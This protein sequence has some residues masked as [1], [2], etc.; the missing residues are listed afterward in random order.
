MKGKKFDATPQDLQGGAGWVPTSQRKRSQNVVSSLKD[1]LRNWFKGLIY[2]FLV[3]VLAKVIQSVVILLMIKSVF[4]LMGSSKKSILFSQSV[5]DF[6]FLHGVVMWCEAL[7]KSTVATRLQNIL[8]SLNPNHSTSNGFINSNSSDLQIYVFCYVIIANFSPFAK[9]RWY[10]SAFEGSMGWVL[11]YMSYA[12]IIVSILRLSGPIVS[13]TYMR[14]LEQK[15]LLFYPSADLD[16]MIIKMLLSEPLLR[17]AHWVLTKSDTALSFALS[18]TFW[19]YATTT[20]YKWHEQYSK[21]HEMSKP[22]YSAKQQNPKRKRSAEPRN[23]SREYSEKLPRFRPGSNTREY[24]EKQPKSRLVSGVN[25][26]ILRERP[27]PFADQNYK[28]GGTILVSESES[29]EITRQ[30]SSILDSKF[31]E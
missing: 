7:T 9:D 22:G 29:E 16:S 21:K 3:N 17:F 12:R 10:R 24:S 27:R 14:D 30:N 1:R 4:A 13:D 5:H 2:R 6:L 8:R 28:S 18:A 19:Y 15:R 31:R 11:E 23:V 26:E 25:R 20:V